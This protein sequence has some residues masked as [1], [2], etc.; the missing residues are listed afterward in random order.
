MYNEKTRKITSLTLMTIMVAGGMTFAI[1]GMP[2]AYAEGVLYVSANENGNFAGIQVV[3]IVVNDP[4]RSDTS[5]SQGIPTVQIGSDDVLM[6]QGNDGAWYAYVASEA[7]VDQYGS[8]ISVL[9]GTSATA[10]TF[11]G[12][13]AVNVFLDVEQF[14]DG[15]RNTSE[16]PNEEFITTAAT[17]ATGTIT[18]NSQPGDG[19]ILSIFD[20]SSTTENYEFDTASNGLNNTGYTLIDT[21]SALDTDDVAGAINATLTVT[22]AL[23]GSSNS[24]SVVNLSTVDTGNDANNTLL[25]ENATANFSFSV[26]TGGADAFD[27]YDGIA[28]GEIDNNPSVNSQQWPFIQTFEI[29]DGDDITISYGSGNDEESIEITYEYDEDQDVNL[30]R[31]RYPDNSFIMIELTDSL[32]NLSPTASE[33][34]VFFTNGTIAYVFEDETSIQVDYTSIGF[35][36]GPLSINDQDNILTFVDTD[37]L[38]TINETDADTSIILKTANLDDNVFVNYDNSQESGLKITDVGRASIS[39]NSA[40]SIL[41]ETFEGFIEF[42][43]SI[44]EWFSGVEID[45]VLIDEDRNLNSLI[46]ESIDILGGEVPY[47]KI[48]SPITIDNNSVEISD[49]TNDITPDST[50]LTDTHTMKITT[51]AATNIVVNATWPALY[52]DEID[53]GYIFPYVNYDFSAFG[54]PKGTVFAGNTTG[55]DNVG[56]NGDNSDDGDVKIYSDGTDAKFQFALDSAI[57]K[58]DVAY[59]DLFFY[60]QLDDVADN[61]GDIVDNIDRV[62]DAIYRFALDETED[63]SSQFEGTLEYIMINQLNVFDQDTYDRIDANSD[64]IIIIV[65]DDMDGS[66]AVTVS[67]NDLDETGGEDTIS[68]TEDANT[69]T[70]VIELDSEGYSAGNTVGV[71]LIDADLN[72]DSD[73]IQI[74][75]VDSTKH[76][77]GNENVWLSQ[78]KIDDTP[79]DGACSS[80]LSLGETN[81]TL[82]ETGDAT[83]IFTGTFRLPAEYC[84]DT[85]NDGVGDTIATTNGL[86]LEFEYQDYSDASGEPNETSSDSTLRSNTGSVKL[87][88]TVYP[89]PFADEAFLTYDGNLSIKDTSGKDES[90]G[91]G[92]VIITIQVNDPDFNIAS[93]GEDKMDSS[94]V[95]LEISRGSE[96][97][98]VVIDSAEELIEIDP[99]SGIFEL[100][101]EIPQTNYG[102]ADNGGII[103]QGD[104]ITVTYSDPNDAS[105]DTNTVTDSA[106]FDLRN[107]VLQTDKKEYVIGSAAIITLIEPD[108]NLDS[109][110]S[111]TWSL[112]LVNWDSDAGDANLSDDGFDANPAG[113]RETGDNTGI[114][115][116]VIEIPQTVDGD[117]LERAEN[118]TLEY[119]DNGPAGADFIGD[120][121]E[122][123][124][125]DIRTSNYGASIT[126][127]QKVYTWTDKVYVTIVSPDHNFDS[128]AIDEIGGTNDNEINI[129]T[130]DGGE[131]EQYKLVETGSDTGIFVG[132]FILTG[133]EHDADG[134]G[135]KTDTPNTTTG[136]GPTSGLLQASDDDGLSISFEASDGDTVIGSAIIRWN[137]GEVQWLESS[138]P[139]SGSGVIRVIDPDMNWNPESVDSFDITVW[140]DSSTGGVSLSVTET[141]EATGIF[142]GTVYFTTTQGSSGSRL[143]VSE[144]DSVTAKYED[145]TL[146][147][148]YSTADE[149]G[150]TAVANIGTVVPPLERAPAG[151]L[152][153]VD[154]FKNSINTV[155]VDQ[156]IQVEAD[157]ANGQDRNQEFAYLVQIQNKD[158]VT[159]KLAWIT[160][161]L[162]PGQNLSPALSWIPDEVGEYTVT[163]FV[164]E[165]VSNPTAL[166]PPITTTI[167]VG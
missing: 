123:V 157:I 139:A 114:F 4:A 11:S 121:D 24:S 132:E 129:Q 69:H 93:S 26:F 99:E 22:S 124:S 6:V 71:T 51:A 92:T 122:D 70:G 74:Y 16:S 13:D 8:D 21:S 116:T 150:V 119:Q 141:N 20:G 83:G 30:D 145:N 34:W 133:F 97:K 55:F 25:S 48:G 130:R 144:G 15:Y 96:Q 138:Y 151:N 125:I 57:S 32:L 56:N 86:D 47:I 18:V 155:S 31:Q 40:H 101:L 154:A 163:A 39:Y 137:I 80:T 54:G 89:V 152:R 156:Q 43:N 67:Y 118:I 59:F 106:T 108:L 127:D 3:E 115:Q 37:I 143:A 1:P 35:E 105:G 49:G 72:T 64:A 77:V 104:I 63:D 158:G 88:A 126:L 98:S 53:S 23:V 28:T 44:E 29:S 112:D 147:E 153:A 148:P 61:N 166:S 12:S 27:T 134:D 90:L 17:N 41:Y 50:T 131:L 87:D 110:S 142:E 79:Y 75:D 94:Y 60:G 81:F 76:W 82:E 46:D 7:A 107:A 136:S 73:T 58:T 65:N 165:S 162:T 140:S 120:D 62:N 128:N 84:E 135:E 103:Q 117:T 45:L 9:Y 10:N 164:W 78:L 161:D 111:E 68:V 146:P 42:N 14:L 95:T 109:G 66:D 36:E 113:F 52:S 102:F 91:E 33:S 38:D 167:S 19:D 100:E 85:N 149:L 5:E 2:N 160:G 159:V